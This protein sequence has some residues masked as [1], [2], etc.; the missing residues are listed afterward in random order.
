MGNRTFL[1][2]CHSLPEQSEITL[3]L[4]P[5][6]IIKKKPYVTKSP[7]LL[8]IVKRLNS[9]CKTTCKT[10]LFQKKFSVQ[11]KILFP[12]PMTT[13]AAELK[14]SLTCSSTGHARSHQDFSSTA[15]RF[16][17]E[18]TDDR[19]PLMHHGSGGGS[20]RRWS[21]RTTSP[22]H[23]RPSSSHLIICHCCVTWQH[24]S[25]I[26]QEPELI[27]KHPLELPKHRC[28]Q[29]Q[30][31]LVSCHINKVHRIVDLDLDM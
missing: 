10:N 14:T 12:L 11:N 17:E 23:W 7:N 9:A 1:I 6:T 18:Q 15:P 8:I 3:N 30:R 29:V 26:A 5:Q 22:P 20:A 2:Q 27:M 28:G 13:F 4:Y 24:D 25:S 19:V 21:S 16:Q 31:H